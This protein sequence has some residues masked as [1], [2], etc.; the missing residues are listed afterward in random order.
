MTFELS[1]DSETHQPNWVCLDLE[2][3]TSESIRKISE[4]HGQVDILI[5]NGGISSRSAAMETPIEIDR[6]LMN[7]NYFGH[8][9][10]TKGRALITSA[11]Y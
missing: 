4:I 3:V 6:K 7:T 9:A 2:D 1:Q 5:N 10:L 11:C 8:V